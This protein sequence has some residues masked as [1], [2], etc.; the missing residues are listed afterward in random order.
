M[1]RHD[2]DRRVGELGHTLLE[3]A[4]LVAAYLRVGKKEQAMRLLADWTEGMQAV[5]GHVDAGSG[6]RDGLG[7]VN[8]ALERGDMVGVA[9]ALSYVV[10]PGL[11]AWLRTLPGRIE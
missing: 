8:T 6:V 11:D 10:I 2:L 9:D 1:D 5:L 3:A 7:E 4:D